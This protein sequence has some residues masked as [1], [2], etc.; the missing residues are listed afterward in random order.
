MSP[1]GAQTLAGYGWP[2][3]KL[4]AKWA[5]VVR[6]GAAVCSRCG[7]S[8]GRDEPWDLDHTDDRRGWLGPAHPKCNRATASRPVKRTS[9]A[10]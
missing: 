1:K 8:F 7:E 4:R 10:W 9:R 5:K 6:A 2:H 3:Q